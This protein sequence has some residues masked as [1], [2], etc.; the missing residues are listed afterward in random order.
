MKRTVGRKFR[1]DP[2]VD[3]AEI[4]VGGLQ[5]LRLLP[6]VRAPDGF[7]QGTDVSALPVF[8]YR[9]FDE[10]RNPFG[11]LLAV[12]SRQKPRAAREELPGQIN[13]DKVFD[14]VG[15]KVDT[16]LKIVD[17]IFVCRHAV[18]IVLKIFQCMIHR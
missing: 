14:E 8:G 17:D 11:E 12:D 3:P 4:V 18:G 5:P 6:V 9:P 15:H 7:K 13:P 10:N 1:I 16:R 2:F